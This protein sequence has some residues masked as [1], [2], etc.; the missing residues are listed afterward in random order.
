MTSRIDAAR[1]ILV[2][3]ETIK[4]IEGPLESAFPVERNWLDGEL[5]AQDIE[6]PDLDGQLAHLEGLWDGL[7]SGW[8]VEPTRCSD[9][10]VREGMAGVDRGRLAPAGSQANATQRFDLVLRSQAAGDATLLRCRSAVG[11]LDLRD[12]AALDALYELQIASGH[13][14]VCVE[15]DLRS[16]DDIVFIQHDILFHPNTTQ[17]EECVAL[18]ERTA[19]AAK[20]I[21]DDLVSAPAEEPK[22]RRKGDRRKEGAR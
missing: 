13:A 3:L 4:P 19:A 1:E 7:V 15:P 14:K 6:K 11:R 10:L 21:H 17:L 18:V 8:R 12:D 5:G 2:E 9:P 20:Q 16:R 22:R